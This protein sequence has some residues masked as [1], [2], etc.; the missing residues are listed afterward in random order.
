MLTTPFTGSSGDAPLVT[1]TGDLQPEW[2]IPVNQHLLIISRN[3]SWL[4]HGFHK[5]PA[6]FFPELPRWAIRKYS[7]EGE[8]VQIGR[9]HV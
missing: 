4:S 7:G 9:A 2:D 1:I 5:Y 8:H 3:Q 6:K